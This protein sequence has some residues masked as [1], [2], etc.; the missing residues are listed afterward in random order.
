MAKYVGKIFKVDNAK[1]KIRGNEA[2]YVHVK[3]YN[4]LT[5]RFKCKVITSLENKHVIKDGNKRILGTTPYIQADNGVYNIFDKKKYKKL[6]NGDIVPIPVSK[7][8]GF[9]IWTGYE[10]TRNLHISA[11]KGK[12]QKHLGIKK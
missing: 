7:A 5:K 9:D 10:E 11:L 12:E 4:P 3:W 6:R 1:L 8:R 2:H